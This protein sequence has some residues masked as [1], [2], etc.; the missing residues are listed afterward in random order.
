MTQF[1]WAGTDTPELNDALA[2][3]LASRIDG[4][5]TF[6]PPYTTL[7]LFENNQPFAVVLFNNWHPKEGVVEMHGASDSKRW[8]TRRSIKEMF[9]YVFNQ[10]G[11]QMA[12][13]RVSE[14]NKVLHR[15]LHAYGFESHFISRLRGRDEGEFIFTLTDDDWRSNRFHKDYA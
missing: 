6:Q 13:M 7:G 3:W 14:R 1:V 12:L 5:D 8:L 2:Q 10:L 9:G 15:I 11:C 4:V